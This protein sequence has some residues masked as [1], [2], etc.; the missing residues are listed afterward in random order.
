MTIGPIPAKATLRSLLSLH[1]GRLG[2]TASAIEALV[3]QSQ[4]THW[5]AGQQ[6]FAAE[7]THDL[8]NFLVAGAVKVICPGQRRF[9]VLVQMVRPGQFFGLASLFDRSRVRQ[10]GAVAHVPA[11]VAMMS[12]EV[13][14]NVFAGLPPGNALQLMAYSWRAL[15]RLLY[16]KCLLL[17]MPLRERLLHELEMLAH[18]FGEP[19]AAGTLI[20]LPL[21]HADLAQLVVGSRAKVSRCVA[22]LRRSG[23]IELVEN[24]RL[25]LRREPGTASGRGVPVVPLGT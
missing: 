11:L 9:P 1:A 15:S 21:T 5:R 22:E 8:A 12:Q 25:L 16:E 3:S 19:R 13:I 7:D 6:I 20:D 10:F 18:D 2:L 23:E 17:T 14:T 24:R 4:V